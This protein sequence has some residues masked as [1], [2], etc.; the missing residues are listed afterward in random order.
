MKSFKRLIFALGTFQ[1]ARFSYNVGYEV[2]ARNYREPYNLKDRY[3]ENSYAVVT[4]ST[5]GLGKSYAKE[6]ARRG[7]NVV[8]VARNE[9]KL[10]LVNPLRT[11]YI[12]IDI[13]KISTFQCSFFL[14]L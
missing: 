5:D 3:G 2:Y 11:E 8:L 10:A 14:L 12:N 13:S 4:G 6:L 7:L 9:E 1:A